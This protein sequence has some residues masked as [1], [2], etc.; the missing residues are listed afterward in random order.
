[1]AAILDNQLLPDSAAVMAGLRFIVK[2]KRGDQDGLT[3][4]TPHDPL[5]PRRPHLWVRPWPGSGLSR[6]AAPASSG[7]PGWAR[8]G[9]PAGPPVTG[10]AGP[11]G[12]GAGTART[13]ADT[14]TNPPARGGE[15]NTDTQTQAH[16]HAHAHTHIHVQ[17][18]ASTYTHTHTRARKHTEP[19][20]AHQHA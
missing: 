7:G 4:A 3:M 11:C 1:M 13:A 18:H 15:E 6:G 2:R 8:A 12:C 20:H 10:S 16:I 9:A 5:Q 19:F 17:T 14:R